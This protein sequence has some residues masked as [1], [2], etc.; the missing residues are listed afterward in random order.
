MVQCVLLEPEVWELLSQV[1]PAPRSGGNVTLGEFQV[2]RVY[3][4]FWG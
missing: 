1:L 2:T 4:V 3:H